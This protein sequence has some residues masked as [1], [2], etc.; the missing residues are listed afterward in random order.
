MCKPNRAGDGVTQRPKDPKTFILQ[1]VDHA[2]DSVFHKRRPE[3]EQESESEFAQLQIGEELAEMHLAQLLNRL[4]FE[5]DL[6]L[7]DDVSPEPFIEFHSAK[8]N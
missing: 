6:L 4:Q 5:Q 7:H 8:L 3:I 1:S 2:F